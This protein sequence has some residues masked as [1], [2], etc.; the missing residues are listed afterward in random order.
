MNEFIKV[1]PTEFGKLAKI[2]KT[3]W[4][5]AFTELLGAQQ[6]EY[7]VEKF[8]SEAAF[9]RQTATEGYEYYFIVSD[10]ETAGYVAVADHAD[11]LFLSKLYLL[12]EYK[13][14]G[15]GRAGLE[16]V[17]ALAA[18]RDLT[19]VYLT[20]NKHNARAIAV[21][22]CFGFKRIDAIVTDIGNGFVMDDYVYELTV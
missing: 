2:A 15:L 17:K 4:Q 22:E 19:A 12:P 21:Y 13:S 8:Q 3:C 9:E 5:A 1:T 6:V 16:F 10:G 7:M 20:V 18:Q 14:K 11:R